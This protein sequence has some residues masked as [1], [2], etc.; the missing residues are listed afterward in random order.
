[1]LINFSCNI[2]Q[3]FGNYNIFHQ[4]TSPILKGRV[5]MAMVVKQ[6]QIEGV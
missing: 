4:K 1:M 3:K 5:K 2:I 6:R